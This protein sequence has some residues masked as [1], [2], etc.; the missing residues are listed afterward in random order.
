MVDAHL[1]EP[2]ART[3]Y[4]ALDL[5]RGLALISMIAYHAL[6]D[7]AY[8]NGEPLPWLDALPGRLW[9]QSICWSFLLLSGFCFP[10]GRR[11]VRRGIVLLLCGALVWLASLLIL[12]EAPIP[13]GV[14]TLL[15]CCTLLTAAASPLLRRVPAAAGAAASFLLFLL[16]FRL[17][18]GVLGFGPLGLAL[19][20]AL[21]RSAATAFF[22]FPPPGY[23]SVDYFPLL[24]WVFLYW[25]GAFLFRLAQR[26]G[27]LPR[28]SAAHCAPLRF[29]GRHALGVYLLHQPVL[30]G[31]GLLWGMLTGQVDLASLF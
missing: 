26:R 21:Y 14:L 18:G 15:G 8:F 11:H 31:L 16:L 1:E 9:Q 13:F 2:S 7:A 5:L 17:P 12:P 29:L 28:L 30:L 20:G 25:T 10:L 19:P 3:R 22:G 27:L 24:P 4:P 6:W 23:S